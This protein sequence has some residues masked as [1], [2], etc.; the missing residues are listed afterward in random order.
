MIDKQLMNQQLKGFLYNFKALSLFAT[1]LKH[2]FDIVVVICRMWLKS[3]YQKKY[4]S[5]EVPQK[6]IK[7]T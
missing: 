4:S 7:W 2:Y 5:S 3:S 1:F 6:L